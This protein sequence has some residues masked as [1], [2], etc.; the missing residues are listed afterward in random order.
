LSNI[1]GGIVAHTSDRLRDVKK[2]QRY[3]RIVTE[4]ATL[5]RE[6]GYEST[7]MEA[8]AEK[9]GVSVGTLYNYHRDKG[10]ML[11][12]VVALEVSEVLDE[13]RKILDTPPPKPQNDL[14][15]L[16]HNYLEHSLHYLSKE[17][18]RAAMALSTLHAD[19]PSG[20]RYAELDRELERQVIELLQ[21]MQDRH[22][23]STELDVT[24]AGRVCFHS[25]NAIFASFVREEDMTLPETLKIVDEQTSL[26]T[27]LMALGT[28]LPSGRN[29]LDA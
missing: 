25:M 26:L 15:R 10:D 8:I 4:A 13:G 28:P 18:W 22:E 2:A 7:K 27:S 24:V 6:R 23:I 29:V 5:F 19:S 20:R 9:A 14:S 1:E 3:R 11:I 16:F 21:K 12:A 17:M